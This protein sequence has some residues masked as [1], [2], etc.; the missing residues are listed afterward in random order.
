MLAAALPLVLGVAL[1]GILV[2]QSA[3]GTDHCVVHGDHAH[4]CIAHGMQWTE[5]TWAIAMITGASVLVLGRAISLLEGW[6]RGRAIVTGVRAVGTIRDQ[7]CW[8]ESERVFCFVSG[9]VHPTIFVSTGARAALTDDEWAAMLAH[10]RGHI[11]HRDLLRRLGME[12][13]LLFAAP[14]ARSRILAAWDAA[15][16]QLRDADAAETTSG[17]AV[18]SALVQMARGVRHTGMLAAFAAA[19]DRALASRVTALLDDVPR[20]EGDARRLARTALLAACGLVIMLALAAD[21]LHHA[22]ETLLG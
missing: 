2:L 3:L 17:T 7:M 14:F 19:G 11:S 22:L 20:G 16:E 1:V 18:A 8:V 13:L 5:R 9:V 12:L 10:E 15:T 4:L 21:P 6:I